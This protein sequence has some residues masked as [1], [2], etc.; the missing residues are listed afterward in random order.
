MNRQSC[1]V[2]KVV[3]VKDATLCSKI[4]RLRGSNLEAF[5]NCI[6]Y[7]AAETETHY[8]IEL[9]EPILK[10][11]GVNGFKRNASMTIHKKYLHVTTE[12]VFPSDI[13]ATKHK[14]SLN[15]ASHFIDSLFQDNMKTNF[16][17][18]EANA[19]HLSKKP[20]FKLIHLPL[21]EYETLIWIQN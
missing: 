16:T 21:T 8:V 10:S 17:S 4:L 19:L 18:L 20:Y 6:A 15:Q 9:T 13:T 1:D 14:S 11:P 5:E 2:N 7:I 12:I 3:K